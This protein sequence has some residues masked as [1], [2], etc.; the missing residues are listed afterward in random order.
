MSTNA[1]IITVDGLSYRVEHQHD[2]DADAPWTDAGHGPVRESSS[3]W[4]SFMERLHKRA[5]ELQLGPFRLYDFAEACRIARRDNWGSWTPESGVSRR[6]FAA[7]QARK[8]YDQLRGWIN[9]EWCYL[10]IDVTLLDMD[11]NPTSIT[12]SLSRVDD[13]DPAYVES[14]EHELAEQCYLAVREKLT[15]DDEGTHLTITAGARTTTWTLAGPNTPDEP[16]G[17]R[18]WEVTR[19]STDV[20][21]VEA[22]TEED[23]IEIAQ[24]AMD[25]WTVGDTDWSAVEA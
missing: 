10:C 25:G 1:K 14:T 2:Y 12:E 3:Y 21:E 20:L 9:D 24:N 7:E 6:Q 23:A 19:V 8:D 5:G 15:Y 16:T 4:N 18:K 13:L 11:G 22:E 17:L